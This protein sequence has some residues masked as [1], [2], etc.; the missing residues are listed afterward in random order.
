MRSGAQENTD[1]KSRRFFITITF[2]ICLHVWL[3]AF[4]RV[5]FNIIGGDPPHVFLDI[6]FR[7][8][9]CHGC[10]VGAGVGYFFLL[11]R[12]I[13]LQAN[14]FVSYQLHIAADFYCCCSVCVF[15][16]SSPLAFRFV[17]S[18]N[19]F[20]S[21]G[22]NFQYCIV[23]SRRYYKKCQRVVFLIIADSDCHFKTSKL[24]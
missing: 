18:N 3:A 9:A 1:W 10:H 7:F 23:K 4:A 19:F 13:L 14:I 12:A 6:D 11:K 2:L 22:I 16:I 24:I 21:Y 20:L 15:C 17:L 5:Y 8:V